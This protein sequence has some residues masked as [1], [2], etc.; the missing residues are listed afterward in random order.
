MLCLLAETKDD[1]L[2][3][4]EI[5]KTEVEKQLERKIKC[6]RLNHGG[7]Y[8]SLIF[9]EFCEEHGIIH[10]RTPPY[11]HQSDGVAERKTCTLIDLVNA[12][13]RNCGFI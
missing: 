10:N 9:D 8:F 12:M 4:F 5:Y 11:S 1:A 13:L 6:L 2:D 3:Y 7:E